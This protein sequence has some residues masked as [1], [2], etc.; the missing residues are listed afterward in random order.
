MTT[1]ANPTKAAI[2]AMARAIFEH[3]E[4]ALGGRGLSWESIGL[5][6]KDYFIGEATAAF[7]AQHGIVRVTPPKATPEML[8]AYEKAWMKDGT[9]TGINAANAAGDLTRPPKERG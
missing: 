8:G 4:K 7:H 5:N 3:R 9:E 1:D 6:S 2:E